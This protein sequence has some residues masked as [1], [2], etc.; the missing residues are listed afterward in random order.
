MS[1]RQS[2]TSRIAKN[3]FVLFIRM[4][5]LMVVNLYSV[6]LVLKGMGTE[7]YGI[8]SLIAGLVLTMS[9]LTGVL[10]SAAQRFYSVADGLCDMQMLR[11]VYSTCI[12]IAII[13]NVFV[14]IIFNNIK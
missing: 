4:F 7:N 13:F 8:F 10:S 1:L 14:I 12:N 3:S 6:R 2:K 9:C 5:V 11:D